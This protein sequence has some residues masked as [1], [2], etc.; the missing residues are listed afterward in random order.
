MRKSTSVTGISCFKGHTQRGHQVR[1]GR[2]KKVF[3]SAPTIFKRTMAGVTFGLG[4]VSVG[5]SVGSYRI[6]QEEGEDPSQTSSGLR[7]GG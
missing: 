7:L 1:E 3:K 4:R 2:P 5:L 6:K